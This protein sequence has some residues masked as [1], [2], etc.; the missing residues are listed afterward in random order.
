[1]NYRPR[2]KPKAECDSSSG[3]IQHR[4]ADSFDCRP[5]RYYID[6]LKK[7][8]HILK[9]LFSFDRYDKYILVTI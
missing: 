1:M 5:E 6:V 3:G 9:E 4:G 2:P 8:T 7:L